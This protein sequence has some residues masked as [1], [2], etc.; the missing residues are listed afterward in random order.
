V[1]EWFLVVERMVIK[2]VVIVVVV[3]SHDRERK[4]R[5]NSLQK[6]TRVLLFNDIWTGF[7]SCSDHE[8]H[9]YL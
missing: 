2:P 9:P 1:V 5:E 7:V 8:I 4:K 3:E 6:K